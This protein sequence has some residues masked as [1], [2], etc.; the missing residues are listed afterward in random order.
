MV[1]GPPPGTPVI[2]RVRCSREG[3]VFQV[4]FIYTSPIPQLLGKSKKK[5]S[6]LHK[7]HNTMGADD[8]SYQPSAPVAGVPV[9][10]PYAQPPPQQPGYNPAVQGQQPGAYPQP[11][12]PMPQQQPFVHPVEAM[13]RDQE[14]GDRLKSETRVNAA[15]TS[16]VIL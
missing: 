5:G 15:L 13:R 7:K 9:Q 10:Q 6:L 1:G 12:H 8:G 3:F 4:N 11:Q 2:P 16:C 14:R